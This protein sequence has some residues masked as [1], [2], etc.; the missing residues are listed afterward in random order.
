MNDTPTELEQ[1]PDDH[2]APPPT[3]ARTWPADAPKPL[4]LQFRF[5]IY[6]PAV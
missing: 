4:N 3:A 5:S 2:G 1:L 6:P